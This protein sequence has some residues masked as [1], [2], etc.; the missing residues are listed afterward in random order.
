MPDAKKEDDIAGESE[1]TDGRYDVVV[2]DISVEPDTNAEPQLGGDEPRPPAGSE[3]DGSPADV[4][5]AIEVVI[6]D[7]PNK[8]DVVAVEFSGAISEEEALEALGVPGV[9]TV[10]NGRPQ[11]ELDEPET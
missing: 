5:I 9:L 6:T 7:G 11:L 8:G 1:L 2:V 10:K 3:L 4:S